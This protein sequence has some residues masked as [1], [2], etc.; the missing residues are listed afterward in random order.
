MTIG[1]QSPAHDHRGPLE[2]ALDRYWFRVTLWKRILLALLLGI[3]VG[4]AWGGGATQIKWVGDLFVRLIR[5]LVAPLVFVIIVSGI[6][7]LGDPRRLGSIGAKTLGLYALTTAIAAALGLALGTLIAPGQGASFTGVTA[8]TIQQGKSLGAQLMA[9][10]PLNPIKSLADG[11]MLSVIF[12]ALLFGSGII[13]AG[14]RAEPLVRVF[15][16]ATAVMLTLVR[17]IMELAPIGVFALI[18]SMIGASGFSAFASIFWLAICVILGSAIQTVIVHGS[19]VRFG[20]WL[21]VLPFFRGSTDAILVGFSTA[22]SSA[23]LPVAMSVAEKNLGLKPPVVSTVLPLGATMSMDGS[24]LYI[25]LM[26]MFG[27]QA[28]GVSLTGA[29]YLIIGMTTVVLAMGTAPIPSASLFILA[30]VLSTIGVHP[31]QT[32]LLVGFILPF[33][34]PLDMIRTIPNVTSDLSVATVVGRWEGEM[35]MDIYKAAPVE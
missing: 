32:A 18:A 21:P 7:A 27:V 5:M 22:S 1:E 16:A 13:V 25:A 8:A 3:V 26:A 10:V 2:I 20:A 4:W 34:R 19:L 6:A 24:A 9:I 12:F 33:D 15:D 30:S 28:F 14:K 11:E 31:E 35:D 23:T 17:L 29:D